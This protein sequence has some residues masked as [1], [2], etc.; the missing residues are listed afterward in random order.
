MCT[1]QRKTKI[2]I[3]K[4][5]NRNRN[6]IFVAKSRT[7]IQNITKTMLISKIQHMLNEHE[8]ILI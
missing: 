1:L 6:Y 4:H 8:T 7:E 2:D 3:I 5:N